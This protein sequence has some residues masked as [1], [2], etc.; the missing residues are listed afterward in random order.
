VVVLEKKEWKKEAEI[1]MGES[2]EGAIPEK[3]R[4]DDSYQKG[5]NGGS[6]QSA[7]RGCRE[8]S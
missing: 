4:T 7:C 3:E 1:K 2:K 8:F 5:F 6:S